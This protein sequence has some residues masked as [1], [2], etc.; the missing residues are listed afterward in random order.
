LAQNNANAPLALILSNHG[1]SAKINNEVILTD[2]PGNIVFDSLLNIDEINGGF[3]SRLDVI[4]TMPGG[5]QIFECFGDVGGTTEQAIQNNFINFSNSS[6]HVLLSAFDPNNYKYS[7]QVEIEEWEIS[8]KKWNVF[9]GSLV[10]KTNNSNFDP[11]SYVMQFFTLIEKAVKS[12]ILTE[13]T[14]WFRAYYLQVEDKIASIEFLKD[15]DPVPGGETFF[16]NLPIIPGNSFFSCRNFMILKQ[17][18]E[19]PVKPKAK[20]FGLFKRS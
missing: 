15:N 19:S 10:P 14:H 17:K 9:L 3:S 18:D 16:T 1:V 13:K 20:W 11:S 6:L 8:G 2:L 12:Q 5:Q 7:E 4:A